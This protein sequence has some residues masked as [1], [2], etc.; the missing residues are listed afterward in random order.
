MTKLKRTL[1]TSAGENV[2]KLEPFYIAGGSVE[3]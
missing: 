3:G 2:E 1:L